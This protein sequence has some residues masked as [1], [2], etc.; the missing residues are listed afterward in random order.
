M[1]AALSPAPAAP[2]APSV[3]ALRATCAPPTTIATR[4]AT[5]TTR[6]ATRAADKTARR[7]SSTLAQTQTMRCTTTGGRRER[8]GAPALR[9]LHVPPRWRGTTRPACRT[10]TATCRRP[11]QLQPAAHQPAPGPTATPAEPMFSVAEADRAAAL[12]TPSPAPSRVQVPEPAKPRA[13]QPAAAPTLAPQSA[14]PD[15]QLQ[16]TQALGA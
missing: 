11:H 4:S 1:R 3:A 6:R 13:M 7:T 15:P 2:R 14:T 10:S 16:P 8:G 5:C 9:G 12:N